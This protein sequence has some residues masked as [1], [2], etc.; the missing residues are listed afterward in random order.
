MSAARVA[1]HSR[2]V[3]ARHA[4]EE[5]WGTRTWLLIYFWSGIGGNL[6]S[7]AMNFTGRPPPAFAAKKN[8]S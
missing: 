3:A 7:C 2:R 8:I 1:A 6:F 5:K 4:L